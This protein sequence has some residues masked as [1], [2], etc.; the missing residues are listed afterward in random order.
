MVTIWFNRPTYTTNKISITLPMSTK[1]YLTHYKSYTFEIIKTLEIVELYQSTFIVYTAT[2]TS[3]HLHI[4]YNHKS[5]E[6]KKL[7]CQSKLNKFN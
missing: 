1:R 6:I 3:I 2:S 5:N 7:L 4:I